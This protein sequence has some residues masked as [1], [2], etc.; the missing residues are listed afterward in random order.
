MGMSRAPHLAALFLCSY[1][2]DLTP[3]PLKKIESRLTHSTNF[4]LCHFFACTLKERE[5]ERE[6]E[7]KKIS[8]FPFRTFDIFC[9]NISMGLVYGV[10]I[11]QLIRYSG[12][13]GY[14]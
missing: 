4:T 2:V 6:R 12:A 7:R 3:Y 14:Y 8:I 1:A 13:C 11:S 10:Y 5:R 9:S